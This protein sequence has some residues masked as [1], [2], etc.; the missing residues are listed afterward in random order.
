MYIADVMSIA[1]RQHGWVIRAVGLDWLGYMSACMVTNEQCCNCV[2]QLN[3]LLVGESTCPHICGF[4]PFW[5][6]CEARLQN[7]MGR[8]PTTHPMHNIGMHEFQDEGEGM[9]LGECS[10]L[11]YLFS[12]KL[13]L[14]VRAAFLSLLKVIYAIPRDV[15]DVTCVVRLLVAAP[16]TLVAGPFNGFAIKGAYQRILH[17]ILDVDKN[18]H[19]SSLVEVGIRKLIY[20]F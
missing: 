3:I 1:A 18:W 10:L 8:W 5:L 6:Q 13:A 14:H 12:H 16:K 17:G 2:L 11:A 7:P 19:P 4:Q 9:R 15:C 20:A